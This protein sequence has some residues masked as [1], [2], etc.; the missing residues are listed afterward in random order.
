MSRY[1]GTRIGLVAAALLA[2]VLAA[3]PATAGQIPSAAANN[4]LTY[5]AAAGSAVS[6]NDVLQANLQTGT[7]ATFYNSTSGSTGVSCATSTFTASVLTNPAAPGT[8]TENLTGQ[9]F[10]NCTSNVPGTTGV[11]SVIV[12]NLP[13]PTSVTSSGTVRVAG[14][15]STAPLQA[16]VSLRSIIG[17]TVCTYRANGNAITGVAS[18]ATNSIVF[19]NQVFTKAS[20]PITCFSTAYFSVRYAPVRDITKTGSPTVFV[21]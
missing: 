20:G 15:S 16:T 12:N 10:L 8:A 7:A 13:F 6:V 4:V 11:N 17:E 2:A 19:T 9:T 14:R 1:G 21:N 3:T 5:G 18:N